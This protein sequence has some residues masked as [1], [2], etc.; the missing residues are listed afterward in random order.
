MLELVKPPT[1]NRSAPLAV[2]H[3]H[4]A[5]FI[6]RLFYSP[7]NF[8]SPEITIHTPDARIPAASAASH[9]SH[10]FFSSLFFSNWLLCVAQ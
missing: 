3:K 4:E 2:I 7:H 9:K 8:I 1:L 10:C 5:G 6:A